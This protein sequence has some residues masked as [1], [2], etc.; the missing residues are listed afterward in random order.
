M[1]YI[2]LI[3]SVVPTGERDSPAAKMPRSTLSVNEIW[4]RIVHDQWIVGVDVENTSE[5][6]QTSL[7]C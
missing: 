4:Q 6:Y 1:K 7:Y 5:R 2:S 3:N